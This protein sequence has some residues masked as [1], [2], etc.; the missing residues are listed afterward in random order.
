MLRLERLY[1]GIR[2]FDQ[3]GLG[4]DHIHSMG[5]KFMLCRCDIS[6]N[7]S[8]NLLGKDFS[9]WCIHP[10]TSSRVKSGLS[11]MSSSKRVALLP[12][13]SESQLPSSMLAPSRN[14]RRRLILRERS[15]QSVICGSVSYREVRAAYD[16]GRSWVLR[17][18]RLSTWRSRKRRSN[19]SCVL[20]HF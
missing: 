4:S 18:P 1:K 20:V 7:S 15:S 2:F 3:G 10:L 8:K 5:K 17:V 6:V 16:Q 19:R 13:T 14:F 11:M 12:S 9:L